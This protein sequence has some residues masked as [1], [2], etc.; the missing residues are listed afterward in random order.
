MQEA[1]SGLNE[2]PAHSIDSFHRGR[3]FLAQPLGRGHRAGTDAMMLASC[4]PTDFNGQLAD[5]G[6]GAGAA[7]LA[8]LARCEQARA[9]LIERSPEMILWAERSLSL[10]ENAH[11]RDRA[12]LLQADVSLSGLL[13]GQAGLADNHYD[14]VIMNPPFN[15][16]PDRHSP[17]D[18][19][20]EAHVMEPDLLEKWLR[21][22]AAILRPRGMLA[23]ISR[24]QSLDQLIAACHARFGNLELKAIH[25]RPGADANRILLRAVKGARGNLSIKPPLILHGVQGNEFTEQAIEINNGLATLFD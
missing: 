11:L 3:F 16:R 18:L 12:H 2:W 9:D 4:V 14:F 20:R 15:L 5:L 13:R 7:A 23:L 8:V 22:A 10:D 24:P 1:S 25:P 6:A 19:R 21:T 17:D